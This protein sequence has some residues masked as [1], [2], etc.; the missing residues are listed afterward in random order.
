MGLSLKLQ[1]L[2]R[3]KDIALLLI[4]YGRRDLVNVAGLDSALDEESAPVATADPAATELADDLERM[5]PTFI[6]L[7]QLLST[8]PDILPPPYLHALVRLQDRVGAGSRSC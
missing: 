1:H 6:K 3:Y 5:G 7:G 8:R 2:K 4:K